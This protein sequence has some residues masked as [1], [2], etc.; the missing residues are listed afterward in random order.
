MISPYFQDHMLG[1]VCF[2][3]GLD[4]Q[5]GLHIKSFWEGDQAICEWLPEEKYHGW[6]NLLSGGILATVIDCHCMG[7]AMADAYKNEGRE[8]NSA[9]HYRYATGTMNIKYLKPTPVH[10]KVRIVAEVTER[11]GKKVVMT[12]SS[13]SGDTKTAEAEVI[14]IQVFNSNDTKDTNPFIDK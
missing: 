11:K 12:C 6:A 10:Q 3:C 5:D 1:N 8:L 2:G 9:P 4:N 13:W 14:A 7:T